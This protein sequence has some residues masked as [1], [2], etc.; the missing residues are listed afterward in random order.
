MSERE[1]LESEMDS[2]I[3]GFERRIEKL[4][5]HN[6]TFSDMNLKL[7][8]KNTKIREERD[9]L[10]QKITNAPNVWVA[11]D[12]DGALFG[13]QASPSR[14]MGKAIEHTWVNTTGRASLMD[15]NLFPD[16]KWENE[17][18][19]VALLTPEEMDGK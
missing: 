12:K 11:R 8:K 2:I 9:A 18:M 1:R 19:Q 5:E 17:P 4:K 14:Y 10:I 3:A 6:Q 7:A 15:K 13:Y 16:L